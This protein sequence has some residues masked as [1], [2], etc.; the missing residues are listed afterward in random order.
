MQA[1]DFPARHQSPMLKNIRRLT[2]AIF[3]LLFLW[4]FLSTESRGANELG[5]PVKIFLD[6]DPLLTLTTILSTRRLDNPFLL[7]LFVLIATVVLGRVFCGWI[8][9]LGTLHNMVSSLKRRNVTG[10]PRNLYLWKYL[11]LIFLLVS[12]AFSL[13]LAGIADPLS[14]LIR[15]LTLAVYPLI[16]YATVSV[17]DTVYAWNFPVVTDISEFIY[18]LLKKTFLSFHQPHFQQSVL[19]GLLFFGIL[20]LNL[21]EKRFWCKYLCP[22]GALL[23]LCSRYALL[24]LSVSESC[25]GCGSCS[26]VCP[27]GALP[28]SRKN[29][30]KPECLVCMNCDDLCPRNAVRFGFSRK[31][32]GAALDLGKRRVIGSIVAGLVAVPLFKVSPLKKAGAAEPRLIRPPGSLEETEFLKRCIKCGQCIKV[33]ITGGLQPTLLEAGLDGIW[34]PVLVPRIGYCEYRCTLCGQ[35]CPTGAIR[36]LALEEKAAVRIGTA[37]IDKGRCLPFAHA[38]PCIVCQEVCP[39][40]QKAIWLEAVRVKNRTGRTMTLR[41]PHVDL[42]LCVG[43][44]ICEAKCPVLGQPAIRATSIG[45]SR[46]QDNQLLL[47]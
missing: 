29:W 47:P 15:S 18:D 28:D 7:A 23:G 4:L 27:G 8:C 40:P 12:S 17:F 10:K 36:E 32:S 14:L 41:Q 20:A 35:V 26:E 43:C 30:R 13:Q 37:M 34:S 46:S 3:L 45:E 31:P 2:Q 5:Y 42:E 44:G 11:L 25:N 39:T 33:C 19:V 1:P 6:A 22:L 24:N 21:A 16:Q 9:P 38:T